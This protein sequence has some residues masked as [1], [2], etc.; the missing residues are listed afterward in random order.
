MPGKSGK[1]ILREVTQA[2]LSSAVIMLTAVDDVQ[3][4][5]E[6]MKLGA[7]DYLVKPVARE[8]LSKTVRSA[9][10]HQELMGE[11]RRLSRHLMSRTLDRPDHFS[12]IITG[13]STLTGLF[14][15]IEAIA[16]SSHPVLVCGET[17]TGKELIARAIHNSSERQGEF[18]PV[19]I[20][21]LD[22]QLVSDTLFGHVKGAF[23][24]AQAAREGL[25]AQ[26]HDGTLFL[27][28]IGDLGPESQVKLLRLLQERQ[29]YPLGSDRV[30]QATSRMV[31]ATNRNLEEEVAS[32][33]FRADLFYRLQT[34]RMEIPPLRERVEDIPLLVDHFV[35][36]AAKDLNR[37]VPEIPSKLY[38]IL[39][40][41]PFSGNIRELESM[42]VDAVSLC[43][44][45]TID[46]DII[47]ERIGRP[48]SKP[49]NDHF[50]SEELV[51][52]PSTLPELREIE[53]ILIQEALRRASG[54]Q[55]QAAHLLN[56][57][58]QTLNTRLVK[59]RKGT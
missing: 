20:A 33:N 11:N 41:Y 7:F 4:A 1:D 53:P 39:M 47:L 12:H 29:Y 27:D 14:G 43:R 17:G 15:Y 30:R 32:G 54:N 31:V 26:A 6:C 21:G 52:F 58:R 59:A 16:P 2:G 10:E 36:K 55:T 44:G 9:V 24:G 13:S 35:E 45:K 19:N 3:S 46:P 34:H 56:I 42:V 8:R 51:K 38:T 28:E 49:G 23:T 18:V 5:V 50:P 37:P 48:E 57:S 25:I 22:D 40:N